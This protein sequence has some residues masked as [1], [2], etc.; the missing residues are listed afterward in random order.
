[1]ST[2]KKPKPDKNKIIDKEKLLTRPLRNTETSNKK[3]ARSDARKLSNPEQGGQ[4]GEKLVRGSAAMIQLIENVVKYSVPVSPMELHLALSETDEKESKPAGTKSKTAKKPTISEP[5]HLR[6][7]EPEYMRSLLAGHIMYCSE[8]LRTVPV[9]Q[10]PVI[11]NNP[12]SRA[13]IFKGLR[14]RCPKWNPHPFDHIEGRPQSEDPYPIFSGRR[15]MKLPKKWPSFNIDL[16]RRRDALIDDIEIRAGAKAAC[17]TRV[18]F[19]LLIG[20]QCVYT[21][22]KKDKI[23]SPEYRLHPNEAMRTLLAIFNRNPS[24]VFETCRICPEGY[25]MDVISMEDGTGFVAAHISP[26]H[27]TYYC[28]SGA[29]SF[30]V[31]LY[32]QRF[33][34]AKNC[35]INSMYHIQTAA[36]LFI[37]FSGSK[38]V[39]MTKGGSYFFRIG[40]QVYDATIFDFPRGWFPDFATD[41][42][43]QYKIP[44]N[45]PQSP[46]GEYYFAFLIWKLRNGHPLSD[47][48]RKLFEAWFMDQTPSQAK[49]IC[50][51][52]RSVG[53]EIPMGCIKFMNMSPEEQAFHSRFLVPE[54]HS[55]ILTALIDE[56]I[57]SREWAQ[58]LG[59]CPVFVEGPI[60]GLSRHEMV[61]DVKIQ[62]HPP[63]MTAGNAQTNTSNSKH[64][65]NLGPAQSIARTMYYYGACPPLK[66]LPNLAPPIR[67]APPTNEKVPAQQSRAQGTSAPIGPTFTVLGPGYQFTGVPNVPA[68]AVPQFSPVPSFGWENTPFKMF[69]AKLSGYSK[70]AVEEALGLPPGIS[71]SDL[72]DGDVIYDLVD[73]FI[74]KPG[75]L[76]QVIE[77]VGLKMTQEAAKAQQ[78]DYPFRQPKPVSELPPGLKKTEI[79][80]GYAY[81][82]GDSR[83]EILLKVE[84]C[85]TNAKAQKAAG[86]QKQ[87]N[88]GQLPT[89]VIPKS[90]ATAVKPATTE[91]QQKYKKAPTN[92][93]PNIKSRAGANPSLSRSPL[94]G[95]PRDL[96]GTPSMPGPRKSPPG[97]PPAA[98]IIAAKRVLL[99][100]TIL[101]PEIPGF[102]RY[103]APMSSFGM[104]GID[105]KTHQQY[106]S[107]GEWLISEAGKKWKKMLRERG[108][109]GKITEEINKTGW[110][111]VKRATPSISAADESVKY[112]RELVDLAKTFGDRMIEFLALPPEQRDDDDY[113][114]ILGQRDK[115]TQVSSYH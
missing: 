68:H 69:A 99:P 37:G 18:V 57:F 54:I 81:V 22:Q 104:Y 33:N 53:R 86:A 55:G 5:E 43:I 85:F 25:S 73:G 67:P 94:S 108:V 101:E 75:A 30:D 74:M 96:R 3:K 21:L 113:A 95:P 41:F 107:P 61:A 114:G 40:R 72:T 70:I 50:D 62:A 27:V 87:G 66:T 56:G 26:Q 8:G 83:D 39:Y 93:L 58:S 82:K 1:M 76:A 45:L 17:Q 63:E 32:Y 31:A 34:K 24:Y 97:P 47:M 105:E 102:N 64:N 91:Q 16:L 65:E 112:Q 14:F 36:N 19:D 88:N 51:D 42:S 49:E 103:K 15:K 20:K 92:A 7:P 48:D 52:I 106:F 9:S 29:E 79:G 46:D 10:F 90:E 59:L 12:S 44:S 89:A 23:D 28:N 110:V 60:E 80:K 98:A 111:L 77:R 109:T 6:V 71:L 100:G 35:T 78:K 84:D 2:I 11:T 115:D 38:A 4:A 13:I